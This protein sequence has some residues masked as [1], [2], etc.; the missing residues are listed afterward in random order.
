[1]NEFELNP[2][3]STDRTSGL[4]DILLSPRR[5]VERFGPPS[6]AD[7]Y[8]V[9][10]TYAFTDKSGAVYTLYDWKATSLYGD[11]ADRGEENPNPPPEEFWDS[12][13]PELLMIGGHDGANVE[14]F[15]RWLIGEVDR[16]T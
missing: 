10:G 3:V 6:E 2:D 12:V 13:E 1:M 8:K 15:K 16:L 5:L 9:S 11:Y 4:G 14:A 7:G